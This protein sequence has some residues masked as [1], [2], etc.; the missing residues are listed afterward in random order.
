[1]NRISNKKINK[2]LAKILWFS[3]AIFILTGCGKVNEE[4]SI[5]EN[6]IT[7]AEEIAS[8]VSENVIPIEATVAIELKFDVPSRFRASKSNTENNQ[9]YV[10]E[11]DNDNSYICYI[12]QDK[13]RDMDYTKL[14]EDDFR[15]A[16]EQQLETQ[17][18][19]ISTEL[20][21]IN[22]YDETVITLTY[23]R[24]DVKYNV[25]ECI[26]ITEK[27]LF[28]V[29]YAMDNT[30]SWGRDFENS[31]NSIVLESTLTQMEGTGISMNEN[32]I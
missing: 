24:D 1:M 25:T 26:F 28:T 18:Q 11:N 14:T 10:S 12:R 2:K 32:D 16:L 8:G 21:Q 9:T 5:S 7:V 4:E 20:K 31:R 13:D 22:G 23:T 29:V 27:Y 19:I 6:G 3:L 15:V 17:V 30:A